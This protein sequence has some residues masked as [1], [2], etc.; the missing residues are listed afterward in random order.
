MWRVRN[1]ST[2]KEQVWYEAELVDKIRANCKETSKFYSDCIV[3]NREN[4]GQL[5][6]EEQMTWFMGRLHHAD[7]ILR[8][9]EQYEKERK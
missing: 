5:Y 1:E 8:I 6:D 4:N 9:I 2:G 7:E 3:K